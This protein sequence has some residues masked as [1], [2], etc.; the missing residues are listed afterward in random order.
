MS[1][2]TSVPAP[3]SHTSVV[4]ALGRRI[5][6]GA[7]AV[8]DVVTL[9]DV[10]AEFQISRTVAREAARVLEAHGLIASRR[11]VGLVVRPREQWD[12]LDVTVIEWMLDGPDRNETLL[13]L[14]QLRTAVEPLAA[15]LA[16][17][18]ATSAQRAQLV[19]WAEELSELGQRGEGAGEAYLAA[20][21]RYHSL[22]LR[23]SGN[24]LFVRLIEPIAEVL[25]G[26]SQRGLTPSVPR[27]GTLEAHVE[28]ASA[29]FR[30]DAE[31][32]EHAARRHLVLVAREVEPL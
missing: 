26:R 13:E 18:R 32:A 31:A 5:A 9:A 8:G 17:Q 16:A 4:D 23:A 1:K 14:T 30:G 27:V 25:R 7:L 15:R 2:P 3:V 11:R 10:E 6:G 24:A 28:T 22:L 21:I 12:S 20:D 19:R 29:I